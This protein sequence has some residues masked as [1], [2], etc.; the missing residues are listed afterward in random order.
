MDATQ[1]AL[2][3]AE[4]FYAKLGFSR[5]VGFGQRPA[6][7]VIDCI[8]GC[9]DPAVSSMGIPMDAELANI[10][11]LMDACREKGFPIVHTT[12]VYSEEEFRDG[13]WFIKKIPALEALR[14]GAKETQFMP[15]VM[16][17]P[18]ELVIEKRY[19][20]GFYGTHLQSF[21]TGC[22]VDT[23]IVT[24]D[25]T[26]G[27]VRATAVDAVSGG[28]RVI[29]PRQCVADR[30]ALSHAVNLFDIDSKYGDVMDVDDVLAALRAIPAS[31]RAS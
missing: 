24:G 31:R 4:G 8:H 16:P 22:G 26:S 14:P 7:L 11:R 2:T 15:E 27:C 28:F 13:G 3:Q 18:G 30:V 5:R 21:L 29:V 6:L 12:V 25:S 1:I 17:R 20:S 23:A 10:R 19:P 9:S